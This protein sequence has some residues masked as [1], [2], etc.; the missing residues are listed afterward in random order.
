MKRMSSISLTLFAAALVFVLGA[1][2]PSVRMKPDVLTKGEVKR[3]SVTVGTVNNKRPEGRGSQSFGLVGRVRGGYG[4]PFALRTASGKEVDVLLK[5]VIKAS[6]EH[7]GYSADQAAKQPPRLDIDV[8]TFWCDGYTGYKIGSE[9]VAKLIDPS[10]GKILAQKVITVN[11]GFAL[12][13][14]YTPMHNAFNE[15]MSDV[16]KELVAFLLTDEFQAAAR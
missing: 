6:L 16:Q 4:N 2:V 7:T 3:G 8:L 1:C 15:V 12:V 5:D 14:N 11:R 9:M 13:V 10:D